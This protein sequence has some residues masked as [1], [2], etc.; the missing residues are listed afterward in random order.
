MINELKNEIE[1]RIRSLKNEIKNS[2]SHFPSQMGFIKSRI[3]FIKSIRSF[4]LSGF[5]GKALIKNRHSR[6]DRGSLPPHQVHLSRW[7]LSPAGMRIPVTGNNPKEPEP[8]TMDRLKLCRR[9][10]GQMKRTVKNCFPSYPNDLI[11]RNGE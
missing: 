10:P 9:S 7:G 8:L 11:S 5:P 1:H 6:H 2:R 3:Y 4:H